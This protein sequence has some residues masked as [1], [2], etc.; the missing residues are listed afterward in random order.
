KLKAF[1]NPQPSWGFSVHNQALVTARAFLFQGSIFV[2]MTLALHALYNY[3]P[4]KA[5]GY[6]YA[7]SQ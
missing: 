4:C 5:E 2:V 7:S 1:R 6:I 3:H